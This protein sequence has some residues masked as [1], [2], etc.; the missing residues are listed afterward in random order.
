MG[1]GEQSVVD[2]QLRVIGVDGLRVVDASVMPTVPG[3][4]TNASVVMI[5]EKAS[6]LIRGRSL[7]RA[8]I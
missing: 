5:A 7:P 4:N 6:D 3:A 2:P 1:Q 8:V